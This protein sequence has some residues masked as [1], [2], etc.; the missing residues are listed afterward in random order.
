MASPEVLGISSGA[1][2]GLA[3]R[4]V[5]QGIERGVGH[6]LLDQ[7]L[8]LDLERVDVG[9]GQPERVAGGGVDVAYLVIAAGAALWVGLALWI[10]RRR[11]RGWSRAVGILLP[12]VVIGAGF[13]GLYMIH[14]LRGLGI[15]VHGLE[16][17][18]VADANRDL[19]VG[20][21]VR[22]GLHASG[23]SGTVPLDIAL[24][25]ADETG[26][27]VTVAEDPLTCVALGTGRALEDPV[28]RGVLQGA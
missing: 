12:V 15:A 6:G 21:K 7:P 5:D 3:E 8:G 1:G 13:A 4:G 2:L 10:W 20:I 23:N 17:V 22:V 18:Q 24:Q 25:V 11:G 26:L 27:P 28:Y 9:E 19:I 16:A 14:R